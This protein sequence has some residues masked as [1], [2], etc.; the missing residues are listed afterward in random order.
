MTSE[1][2]KLPPKEVGYESNGSHDHDFEAQATPAAG[3]LARN[4]KGRHM[5]MIAIGRSSRAK[6]AFIA[7]EY[8]PANTSKTAAQKQKT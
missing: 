1:K 3:G 5:Q 2:E 7:S 4:L 8:Q 6:S